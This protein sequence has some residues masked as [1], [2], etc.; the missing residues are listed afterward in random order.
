MLL[1][2]NNYILYFKKKLPLYAL[3]RRYINIL[4]YIYYF[5][6]ASILVI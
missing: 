2:Y 3:I 1:L 4:K 5:I 6:I